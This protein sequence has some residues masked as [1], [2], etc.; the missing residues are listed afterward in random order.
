MSM[1]E[2]EFKL[3]RETNDKMR[4]YV[5]G[6]KLVSPLQAGDAYYGGRTEEF[7]LYNTLQTILAYN[8][9]IITKYECI[10]KYKVL[11]PNEL[12]ITALP[13]GCNGKFLFGLC[14]S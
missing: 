1:W 8:T 14:K 3:T 2:C 7:K 11:P 4:R 9:I 6:S 12:H 5:A 13:T 10:I